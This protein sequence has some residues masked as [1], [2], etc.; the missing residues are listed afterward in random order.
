MIYVALLQRNKWIYKCE[1][2]SCPWRHLIDTS[3]CDKVGHWLTLNTQFSSHFN[4]IFGKIIV[5]IGDK[6]SYFNLKR[7]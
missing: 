3:L 6:N 1:F 5:F 4:V 7:V 2:D